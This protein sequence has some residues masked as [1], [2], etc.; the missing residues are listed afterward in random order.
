M[1][2]KKDFVDTNT[3]CNNELEEV[4]IG[5]FDPNKRSKEKRGRI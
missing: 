4:Q 1:I 5:N 2:M 3:I